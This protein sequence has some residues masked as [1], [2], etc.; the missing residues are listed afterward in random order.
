MKTQVMVLSK[1]V[2]ILDKGGILV[3]EADGLIHRIH[4]YIRQTDPQ[5]LICKFEH[6]SQYT[7]VILHTS[8]EV[9]VIT[10]E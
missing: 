2:E 8:T 3:I 7:K 5:I 1:A 9:T 4:S 10:G 6:H